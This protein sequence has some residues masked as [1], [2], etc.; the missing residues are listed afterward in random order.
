ML[1]KE[2]PTLTI[3]Q[4]AEKLNISSRAVE[5]QIRYLKK[6]GLLSRVGSRR[7]GRWKVSQGALDASTQ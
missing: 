4:L 7:K 3:S 2:K 6:E 1:L 5:M